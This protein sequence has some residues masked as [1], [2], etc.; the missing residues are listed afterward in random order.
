MQKLQGQWQMVPSANELDGGRAGRI[1]MP[2]RREK[3]RGE[4]GSRV[5]SPMAGANPPT[6]GAAAERPG[7]PER[8][9]TTRKMEEIAFGHVAAT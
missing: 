9:E 7:V 6:V 4:G 8:R 1:G 5:C 3:E 2:E